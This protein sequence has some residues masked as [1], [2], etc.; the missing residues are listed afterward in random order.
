MTENTYYIQVTMILK[1]EGI[2]H[3]FSNDHNNTLQK[4]RINNANFIDDMITNN[5]KLY[6]N[7]WDFLN[8]F[9]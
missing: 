3:R 9:L 5:I 7:M 8:F 6:N 2:L 1:H 4:I